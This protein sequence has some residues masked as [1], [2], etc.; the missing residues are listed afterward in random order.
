[1]LRRALWR[2]PDLRKHLPPGTK[3]N[4]LRKQ[5]LLSLAEKL[6]IDIANVTD[7]SAPALTTSTCRDHEVERVPLFD[8][9]T[10]FEGTLDFELK[11]ELF[12]RLVTRRARVVWKNTPDWE[13]YD[14]E[15]RR[16][17][18]GSGYSHIRMEVLIPPDPEVDFVSVDGVAR[19][20][21]CAPVWTDLELLEEGLLP[22][23][24]YDAI[25]EHID[26]LCRQEDAIRRAAYLK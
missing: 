17:V 16:L 10:G 3:V 11:I 2:H 22:E 15:L 23:G 7:K 19:K 25:D 21:P 26:R 24:V 20:E 1:M 13:F 14:M 9:K 8:A 6:K 5:E 18:L 12:G 4:Q